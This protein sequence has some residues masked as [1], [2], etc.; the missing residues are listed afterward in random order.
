MTGTRNKKVARSFEALGVDFDPATPA[1]VAKGFTATN[2]QDAI[3]EAKTGPALDP[4]DPLDLGAMTPATLSVWATERF[5]HVQHTENPGVQGGDVSAQ[6]WARRKLNTVV[7]PAPLQPH[8]PTGYPD[9]AA[10]LDDTIRLPG[11]A[12]YELDAWCTGRN[13]RHIARLEIGT[14]SPEFTVPDAGITTPDSSNVL[15]DFNFCAS[16]ITGTWQR[17]NSYHGPAASKK[18]KVYESG[19]T[20]IVGD[21]I[22]IVSADTDGGAITD[23]EYATVYA[24]AANDFD[25]DYVGSNMNGNIG[26]HPITWISVPA[27]PQAS[28]Y[29][30]VGKLIQ[31]NSSSNAAISTKLLCPVANLSVDNKITV[32][33]ANN[34]ADPGETTFRFAADTIVY[35]SSE[36]PAGSVSTKSNVSAVV[37]V[38]AGYTDVQLY[39]YH[40]ADNTNSTDSGRETNSGA[41]EMYAEVKCERIA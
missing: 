37:T 35:G 33:A 36:D 30:A 12:T 34:D 38:P 11:P 18:I 39:H 24:I 17:I 19:H 22:I 13:S 21:E 3:I 9:L 2:A 10:L 6:R 29:T 32:T 8:T 20:L 41:Q 4:W 15:I 25:V 40:N 1:A 23:Y 26:P 28:S 31:F 16:Q 14:A 27:A 5:Y 7:T